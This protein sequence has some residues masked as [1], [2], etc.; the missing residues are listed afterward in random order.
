MW[1]HLQRSLLQ[2]LNQRRSLK[3]I[4]QGHGCCFEESW[5][6]A[7]CLQ[8]ARKNFIIG[9]VNTSLFPVNSI[10]CSLGCFLC[11][12]PWND[13]LTCGS[14]GPATKLSEDWPAPE[15]AGVLRWRCYL[16]FSKNL[17]HSRR[18]ADVWLREIP[19]IS[20][21]RNWQIFLLLL[22]QSFIFALI[23]LGSGDNHKEVATADIKEVTA[24]VLL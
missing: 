13:D 8:L 15:R 12:M 9:W 7:S 11:V 21:S 23:S 1:N 16:T 19:I 20:R 10:V 18:V 17:S 4:D 14:T 3:S 22:S 24:C 6:C 5:I 2:E